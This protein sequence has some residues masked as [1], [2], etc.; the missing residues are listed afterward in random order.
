MIGPFVL[1]LLSGHLSTFRYKIGIFLTKSAEIGLLGPN[2]GH[3]VTKTQHSPPKRCRGKEV[4][5]SAA[6]DFRSYSGVDYDGPVCG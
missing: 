4:S 3:K 1:L 5:Q 2:L 6:R